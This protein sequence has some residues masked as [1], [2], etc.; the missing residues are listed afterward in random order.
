MR[1]QL[2]IP[3]LLNAAQKIGLNILVEPTRGMYGVVL[4]DS[5]KK[6]YIKDVNF[7]LNLSTSV[8]LAKNKAATS[9][10]L[11]QFG[12]NVPEFTMIYSNE[13]CARIKS[14]DTLIEGLN[15]ARLIGFPSIL[16]PNNM[17]Q[18]SLVFKASNEDE[19]IAF[20]T[21]ILKYSDTAQLQKFYYGNDYRVV[22]LD[23]KILSAYQRV[24]FNIVGDG[25]LNVSELIDKKQQSF[26]FS[27][28]DTNLKKT[29]IRLINKL[30]QQGFSLSSVLPKNKKVF[31][32]DISNLSVGGETIELTRNVHYSF[33]KLALHIAR[34]MNL[35]LCGI[36]IITNDITQ[37][38]NGEYIVI[39]VNS[40]PGLD[41]YAYEG[42]KQEAYVESLYENVLLYIKKKYS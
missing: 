8:S 15:Y 14:S 36:D 17:S 26:T 23:Q 33:V 31:L 1:N 38:N 13:K 4:F 12:Y 37:K 19:Y 3:I 29:D 32:Q 18:G 7:N 30:I 11:K 2:L 34:D 41:N 40:A 5:G 6:F 22:V 35:A 20:A 39:E 9:F 21:E 16:K 42:S 28:R 27:G 10:F 24:P 25:C